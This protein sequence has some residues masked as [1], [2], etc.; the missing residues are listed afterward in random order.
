M[1]VRA[2]IIAAPLARLALRV[3][4]AQIGPADAAA[5]KGAMGAQPNIERLLVGPG[6]DRRRHQM[7]GAAGF[8]YK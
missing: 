7:V 1:S 6:M 4:V 8:P 3:V 2:Q 5:A